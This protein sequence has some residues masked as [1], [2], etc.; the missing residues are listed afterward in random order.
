MW[1]CTA[2]VI[3]WVEDTLDVRAGSYPPADAS[4][5]YAVVQR[6]GGETRYPHDSP[7]YSVQVWTDSDENGEQVALALSAVLPKLASVDA[8]INGVDPET[9]ITQL[10]RDD[11]GHYVWQV[12]FSLHCNIREDS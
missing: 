4:G 3:S 7:R 12:T 2:T 6:V 1:S 9:V 5:D 10:G 8:R 11:N